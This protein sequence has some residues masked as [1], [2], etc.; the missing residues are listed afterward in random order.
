[1]WLR[2]CHPGFVINLRGLFRSYNNTIRC[3]LLQVLNNEN[4]GQKLSVLFFAAHLISPSNSP[5][6]NFQPANL[7]HVFARTHNNL[8]PRTIETH[9][10]RV[11]TDSAPDSRARSIRRAR[12][13][14]PPRRP[15]GSGT[16]ARF[17]VTIPRDKKHVCAFRRSS[18][19]RVANVKAS[20]VNDT[21]SKV[22]RLGTERTRGKSGGSG[23]FVF[24]VKMA[25]GMVA[26][27]A[28]GAWKGQEQ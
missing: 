14:A 15:T 11:R 4:G 7:W 1:M 3:S 20:G 27:V 16:N 19:A 6:I 28:R 8:P 18:E 10:F 12:R 25:S 2:N 21:E 5:N 22:G 9:H 24:W 17:Y 23:M 26:G 13:G